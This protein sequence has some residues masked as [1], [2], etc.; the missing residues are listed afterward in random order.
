VSARP[1]PADPRGLAAFADED[2]LLARLE[3]VLGD[4]SERGARAASNVLVGVAAPERSAYAAGRDAAAPRAASRSKRAAERSVG[5]RRIRTGCLTKLLTSALAL[6]ACA[7]GKLALDADFAPMM[8]AARGLEGITLRHLLEHR[9]GLD[10]SSLTT[11]PHRSDDFIAAARLVNRLAS[12]RL[13]AP[14][15][16]YS[17]SNAGAW[18]TAAALEHATGRRYGALLG[19]FLGELFGEL[20]DE[21]LEAHVDGRRESPGKPCPALGRSLTV[22]VCVLL[23]L[24]RRHA[25]WPSEPTSGARAG[26]PVA[27]LPGF[28]PFERGVCL[29]WKYYGGGWVGH[30]SAWRRASS[31]LR[32]EP[33][34]GIALFVAS[35]GEPAAVWAARLFGPSLP[36]L[37]G[38]RLPRRVAPASGD[39]TV[40]GCVGVYGRAGLT[41]RIDRDSSGVL[42]LDATAARGRRRFPRWARRTLRP[43]GARLYFPDPP[44]DETFPFVEFIAP[45][46]AGFRYLWNGRFV[47]RNT[48]C[49]VILE[50]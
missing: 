25:P 32:V 20:L 30:N 26:E 8:P 5:A 42:V 40:E 23:E 18:L 22:P 41:V 44:A 38:L 13:A 33:R 31:M 7:R 14:G 9:H 21:R 34:R 28:S 4:E 15:E 39:P 24:A 16:L 17:Y 10:D 3:S 29:G 2:A 50:T 19:D 6:R 48:A 12:V 27:A 1:D 43:G 49:P 36:D 37:T 45:C 11:A 46:G 47:L 35:T